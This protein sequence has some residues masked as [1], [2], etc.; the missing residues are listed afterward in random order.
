MAAEGKPA[1]AGDMPARRLDNA[2]ELER[3]AKGC[4]VVS[5]TTWKFSTLPL[6]VSSLTAMR[7]LLPIVA[8]AAA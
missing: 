4:D 6:R 8:I 1:C 2:P 7:I 5:L 3:G